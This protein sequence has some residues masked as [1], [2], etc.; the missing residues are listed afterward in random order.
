MLAPAGA[1]PWPQITST[2]SLPLRTSCRI[3]GTSPPGPLRWGSTTC[4][5][6]AVATAASKA[7][8]P[9]SRMPMPTAVAIQW[10]EVT[11]P[12][13]P[14]ITRRVVKGLG[15]MLPA[16]GFLRVFWR[17]HLIT[18]WRPDQPALRASSMPRRGEQTYSMGTGTSAAMGGG[19]S[20]SFRLRAGELHHLCPLFGLFGDV[21]SE[22]GGRTGNERGAHAIEPP[23]HRGVGEDRV[24]GRIDLAD[25]LGGR[26]LRRTDAIPRT[27]LV[28]RHEIGHGRSI[29]PEVRARRAGDR[30]H[31]QPARG[32]GLGRRW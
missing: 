20:G 12:K 29:G 15:L 10:V 4:S 30:Q 16:M 7:L 14:S 27:R 28:A 13:V 5:V 22:R 32:D 19:F 23:L 2:L 24:D 26:V 3:T 21:L 17:R 6:N 9:R 31:G 8:P 18:A 25:D 11:T 1:G